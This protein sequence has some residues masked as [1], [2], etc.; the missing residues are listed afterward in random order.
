MVS[1]KKKRPLSWEKSGYKKKLVCERCGYRAKS[2]IQL[3]VFHI[4][5]SL[6]NNKPNNLKTI[7]ANCQRLFGVVE[8]N[9]RIGDLVP[10]F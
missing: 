1:S 6:L 8:K 7:C 4:D 5:G 9:W 10:D 2:P 3:D